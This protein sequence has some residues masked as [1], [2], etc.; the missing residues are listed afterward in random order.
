MI[1]DLHCILALEDPSLSVPLSFF[2]GVAHY[3]FKSLV[4]SLLQCLFFCH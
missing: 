2:L 4:L 1:L 3:R